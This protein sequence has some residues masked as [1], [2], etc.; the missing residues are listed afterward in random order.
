MNSKYTNWL[1]W[2]VLSLVLLPLSAL[3][4][5]PADCD[6]GALS[7]PPPFWGNMP[8]TGPHP[9]QPGPPPPAAGMQAPFLSPGLDLTETQQDQLFE[10]M[11]AQ[12]LQHHR[13]E[14]AAQH[15][16]E[17]L[18]QMTANGTLDNAKANQAARAYG[19]AMTQLAL[20]QARLDAQFRALLTPEQRKV[21]ATPARPHQPSGPH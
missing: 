8:F 10:L 5:E 1:A 6:A 14:R 11:H 4:F 13:Q 20:L 12:A 9:V 3:A 2:Q 17:Q 16:L 19:D 7:P 21:L 15:A 18:W